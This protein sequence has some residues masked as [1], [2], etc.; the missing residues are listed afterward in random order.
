VEKEQREFRVGPLKLRRLRV[1]FGFTIEKFWA[2]AI[3]D[4]GTAKKLFKGGP[5]SMK[6]IAKAAKAF[7]ITNHFELLHA[8]ELLALGVDL[9]VPQSQRHILEWVEEPL[10]LSAWERTA[11]GLQYQVA[12]LRHRFLA[13]RFARGKCYELRH[14]PTA[15]RKQLEEHLHRHPS[16][17]ERISKHPNIAENLTAAFVEQGGLW[18]VVDRF[19]DGPTL[20]ERLETGPLEPLDLKKIML[21]IG[22]GLQALHKA[23]IVRREL[24]P[25]FIIL[26]ATD[27]SP[28]LTDFELA[29]LLEGRPTVSPKGGWPDDP[30]RATEVSGEGTVGHQALREETHG[31]PLASVAQ[32]LD[33]GVKV[34]ILMEDGLVRRSRCSG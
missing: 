14:L 6:T 19:E 4:S 2:A 7:G 23:K 26:R 25:R 30:Y 24:A 16:V 31:N 34:A 33:K 9:D 15:E 3:M 29:K 17:C 10:R 21:G 20:K 13:D 27:G 18:W 32:E 5:V 22:E 28:V 8:D 11:N 12:K 1:Q